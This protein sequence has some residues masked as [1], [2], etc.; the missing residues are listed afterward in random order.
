M[1]VAQGKMDGKMR[2]DG[3][4]WVEDDLVLFRD[5]LAKLFK[6]RAETFDVQDR[7]GNDWWK[8]HDQLTGKGELRS[9][10]RTRSNL[11]MH[12]LLRPPRFHVCH[13]RVQRLRSEEEV[14]VRGRMR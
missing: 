3:W 13:R 9:E 5:G 6:G 8:K 1:R 7:L 4:S 12:S 10:S 11:R 14:E 2:L